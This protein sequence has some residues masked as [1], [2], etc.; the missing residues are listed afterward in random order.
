MARV[1]IFSNHLEKL[2]SN[3]LINYFANVTQNDNCINDVDL[4]RKFLTTTNVLVELKNVESLSDFAISGKDFPKNKNPR[5]SGTMGILYILD[6]I[7][8]ASQMA[9]IGD[10]TTDESPTIYISGTI[11]NWLS[12]FWFAPFQTIQSAK[13]IVAKTILKISEALQDPEIR[14]FMENKLNLGLVQ[15]Y[16]DNNSVKIGKTFELNV[17]NGNSFA[18]HKR[19]SQ[20]KMRSPNC[21]DLMINIP[22]Y[23]T[24]DFKTLMKIVTMPSMFHD[25]SNIKHEKSFFVPVDYGSEDMG[26]LF[27]TGNFFYWKSISQIMD[28]DFLSFFETN[29]T[30]NI[31]LEEDNDNA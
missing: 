4:W 18:L 23:F 28:K 8:N 20:L 15:D 31:G 7:R 25:F 9:L 30:V 26:E 16:V 5:L 27:V 10:S 1:K 29:N 3:H 11:S 2:H 22:S 6:F 12:A 14:L 17:L 21:F 19:L 13:L 24:G